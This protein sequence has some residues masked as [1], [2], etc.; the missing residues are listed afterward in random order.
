[1]IAAAYNY[2]LIVELLLSR[3]DIL[4]DKPN[5]RGITPL[6]MAAQKSSKNIVCALLQAGACVNQPCNGNDGA[7]PL[8]V[9]AEYRDEEMLALLLQAG[10]EINW[11]AKNDGDTSHASSVIWP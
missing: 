2:N 3:P 1:M 6:Y 10:A 8:F 11:V 7:T 5:H 4:V 9:A